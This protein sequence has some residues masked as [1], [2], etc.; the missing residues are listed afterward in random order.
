MITLF[1]QLFCTSIL[2]FYGSMPLSKTKLLVRY[3]KSILDYAHI[4]FKTP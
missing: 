3:K 4:D 2:L 1:G